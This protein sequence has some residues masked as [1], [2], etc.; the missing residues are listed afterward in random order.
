MKVYVL[1][2]TQ[3]IQASIDEVWAYFSSP[4]NLSALT[5]AYMKFTVTSKNMPDETY[6]GQIITYKVSP[7]A[8][9]PLFWMTEITQVIKNKL[10]VDEQRVGP[11]KIWHHEH[12]FV[13]Q[14]DGIL[15]TDI[16]HYS[17]PVYIFG[18]LAHKIFIKKQLNDIFEY[19]FNKIEEHFS[20]K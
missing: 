20:K 15:M 17:L 9:I 7:L 12:H 6:P 1:Q 11:Y 5:P 10:F 13:Q 3:L 19:R 14:A 16:V 18:R 2:R 4:A 8:G